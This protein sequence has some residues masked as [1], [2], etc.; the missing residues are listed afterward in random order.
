MAPSPRIR[1]TSRRARAASGAR[2]RRRRSSARATSGLLAQRSAGRS[3]GAAARA[4][5]GTAARGRARCTRKP[6]AQRRRRAPAAVERRT[7]RSAGIS[8]ACKQDERRGAVG[9][10]QRQP[11]AGAQ[12]AARLGQHAV[13][14]ADV[15]QDV[16]DEHRVEGAVGEGQA[17]GVGGDRVRVG[18]AARER[19]LGAR[20][21]DAEA[22]RARLAQVMQVG[23]FAAADLEQPLAGAHDHAARQ[24]RLALREHRI[25]RLPRVA[26]LVRRTP[27]RSLSLLECSPQHRPAR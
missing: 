25:A 27:V 13:D 10:D 14:V 3:R 8:A 24:R 17:R 6:A 21:V 22:Q 1:D 23:A 7:P 5:S 4:R 11:A 2:S 12:H 16:A 15:V 19:G 26:G 20:E 9:L 18:G